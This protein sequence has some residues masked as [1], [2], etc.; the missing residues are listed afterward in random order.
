MLGDAEIEEMA[1]L[2]AAG[3]NSFGIGLLS[4]QTEEW[5][6]GDHRP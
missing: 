5:V 6:A 2:S 1:D 3:P 4:K